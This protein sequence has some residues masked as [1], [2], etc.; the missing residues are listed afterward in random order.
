M[1]HTMGYILNLYVYMDSKQILCKALF[2]FPLIL[3]CT[4]S[5]HTTVLYNVGTDATALVTSIP[6][7]DSNVN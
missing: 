7:C 3:T 2:L 6:E 4:C 5:V 1:L